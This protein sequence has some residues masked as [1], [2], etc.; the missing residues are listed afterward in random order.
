MQLTGEQQEKLSSAVRRRK[1]C[2]ARC[3]SVVRVT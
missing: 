1:E 3:G 2:K